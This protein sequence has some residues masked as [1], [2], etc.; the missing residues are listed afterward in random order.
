MLGRHALEAGIREVIVQL[1]LVVTLHAG[2]RGKV[3]FHMTLQ[4]DRSRWIDAGF[5]PDRASPGLGGFVNRLLDSLAALLS[6]YVV[7]G[8]SFPPHVAMGFGGL[9]A[10]PETALR[11]FGQA[12]FIAGLFKGSLT[13]VRR[14]TKV[15]LAGQCPRKTHSL[16]FVRKAERSRRADPMDRPTFP[17]RGGCL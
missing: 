15:R 1:G 13:P 2:P 8:W 5:K 6:N 7:Q 10:T 14:F 11:R 4:V 9:L 17:R 3:Q 16:P 12:T